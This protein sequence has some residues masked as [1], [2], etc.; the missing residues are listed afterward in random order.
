MSR[1]DT[2]LKKIPQERVAVSQLL[3]NHVACDSNRQSGLDLCAQS[4]EFSRSAVQD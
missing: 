1:I 3:L 4:R 2:D